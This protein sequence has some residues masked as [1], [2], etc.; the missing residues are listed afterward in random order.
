MQE[1][2]NPAEQVVTKTTNMTANMTA[3]TTTNTTATTSTT[4]TED[5]EDARNARVMAQFD[6]LREIISSME[7]QRLDVL[8]VAEEWD[9]ALL[10]SSEFTME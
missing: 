9:D 7:T 10:K 2:G 8:S 4:N 6:E 1:N 3:A 5:T